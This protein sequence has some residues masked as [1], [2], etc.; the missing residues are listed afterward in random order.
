M[1]LLP[2]FPGVDGSWQELTGDDR[3]GSRP[4][5][6]ENDVRTVV[7][8]QNGEA[9]TFGL[10][11]HS[12]RYLQELVRWTWYQSDF[13]ILSYQFICTLL[14]LVADIHLISVPRSSCVSPSSVLTHFTLSLSL[15]LSL[16]SSLSYSTALMSPNNIH[17]LSLKRLLSPSNRGRP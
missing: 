10:F 11:G 12:H 8:P 2:E 15:L 6:S 14:G 13:Y 16:F 17:F 5:I 4:E 7:E 9:R 3:E 1:K